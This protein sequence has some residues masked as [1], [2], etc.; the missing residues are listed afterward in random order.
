MKR[1]DYGNSKLG[2]TLVEL[3]VVLAL[4]AIVFSIAIPSVDI[5]FN[6]AEKNELMTFKRDIVFARNSSVV[7]N[8]TYTLLLD[9][10]NN[11]YKIIKKEKRPKTIR[12]V[13]FSKGIVLKWNNFNS[14]IDF[15]STGT[16]SK[17]GTINLTNKKTQNI[18]I[19]ITMA[20]GKVNLYIDR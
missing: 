7:D 11:G 18:E 2:Y 13:Y 3:L 1:L 6:I 9:I 15:Y 20:T 16:T 8:C 4:F 12:E 19:T 5:I 17:I 14:I 10:R